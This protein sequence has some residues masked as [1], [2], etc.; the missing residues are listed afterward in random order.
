M[1]LDR[2]FRV[3]P[4]SLET[5]DRLD[6]TH[7][8]SLWISLFLLSTSLTHNMLTQKLTGKQAYYC[9]DSVRTFSLVLLCKHG[10][11]MFVNADIFF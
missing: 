4:A 10:F 11:T 2:L 7:S 6:Q 8:F 9:L 5:G 1:P 3:G